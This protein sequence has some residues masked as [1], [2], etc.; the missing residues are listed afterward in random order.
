MKLITPILLFCIFLLST[1]LS[2]QNDCEGAKS[3]RYLH[4]NNVR[5]PIDASGSIFW[6]GSASGYKVAIDDNSITRLRT[7]YAHGLFMSG[8]DPAGEICTAIATYGKSTDQ[9][10]YYPGPIVTNGSTNDS[11]ICTDWDKVWSVSRFEIE[12]HIADWEDNNNIDN[13]IPSIIAWPGKDNPNSEIYNGFELPNTPQG[14]APFQDIDGD[15]IYNPLMGDYPFVHQSEV[16]PEQITW[17]VFNDL[18]IHNESEATPLA[19]E[20]QLT[21]WAFN[22]SNEPLYKN[23]TFCSYKFINKGLETLTDVYLGMWT[24]FDLG[25]YLDDFVGSAPEQ[26][27]Y[28]AYNDDLIDDLDCNGSFGFGENPPVQAVTFLN[29]SLDHFMYSG[30]GLAPSVPDMV[31]T[32]AGIRNV[33]MGKFSD[34]TPI[35]E[36]GTGYETSDIIL[37]HA[38]PGNPNNLDE[39]SM[40]S[41]NSHSGD[42]RGIGS[43][44]IPSMPPLATYEIDVMFSYHRAPNG[45]AYSNVNTMYNGVAT[46]Q[47]YYDNA[48]AESCNL[49]DYCTDDCVWPGDLNADGIANHCDLLNLGFALDENGSTRLGPYH[50]S[51]YDGTAWDFTQV[52]NAN[53]K[54]ADAN[55]DGVVDVTDFDQTLLHYNFTRPDYVP[56]DVYNEGNELIIETSHPFDDFDNVSPGEPLWTRVRFLEEIPNLI[57]IAFSIE[58]DPAYFEFYTGLGGDFFNDEG[59]EFVDNSQVGQLD[60][61]KFLL[62]DEEELFPN[63]NQYPLVLKAQNFIEEPLSSNQTTLRLK[64]V[65]AYLADGTFVQLGGQPATLTFPTIVSTAEIKEV[66]NIRLFPNPTSDKVFIEQSSLQVL[67]INIFDATGQLINQ[68]SAISEQQQEIDLSNYANGIYFIQINT[69]QGITTKKVIKQ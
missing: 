1:L 42:R 58:Y 43:H 28:F 21:S 45:D 41:A 22:C 33:L 3:I 65:K 11:E 36:G 20:I 61:A 69:N 44:F 35:T 52:N 46:L 2:A 25:C 67:A 53:G 7:I 64:N 68:Y 15:G 23:T 6:D 13:P 54:H 24:D 39:W 62:D 57:G 51:P 38:F 12:A 17:T 63:V 55:G 34:G 31:I 40:L 56:N 37:N 14:L 32:P 26:N 5:T 10:D 8:I 18:G 27:T 16:L 60:Y 30:I 48:F 50:W 49:L 9:Y 4:A 19:M 66:E 47:S 29:Q 59:L